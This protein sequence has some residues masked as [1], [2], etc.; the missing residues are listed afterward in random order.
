M[1]ATRNSLTLLVIF[2]Q[3]QTAVCAIDF[4]VR[5]RLQCVL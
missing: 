3:I 2:L 1:S 5:D 4:G